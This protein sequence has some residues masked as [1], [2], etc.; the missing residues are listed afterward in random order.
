M[1]ALQAQEM[2][3]EGEVG[4]AT[5]DKLQLESN[6]RIAKEQL[7]AVSKKEPQELAA[8]VPKRMSGG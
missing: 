3:L 7:A 5:Q 8:S 4:R 6:V 2:L 1:A